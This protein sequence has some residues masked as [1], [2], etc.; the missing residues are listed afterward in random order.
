MRN[1]ML[2]AILMSLSSCS[3]PA[4]TMAKSESQGMSKEACYA[5]EQNRTATINVAIEK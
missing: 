3:S 5:A 4:E 1:L 2:A